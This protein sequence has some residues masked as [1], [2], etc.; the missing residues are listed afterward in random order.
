MFK[1]WLVMNQLTYSWYV[2]DSLY[3]TL[4]TYDS[5]NLL[6]VESANP[7]KVSDIGNTTVHN[8]H[9]IVD[10]RAE[11]QPPVHPLYQLQ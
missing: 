9:L 10:E 7:V 2:K 5:T 8:Q 4:T 1:V 6:P 11:W 3:V